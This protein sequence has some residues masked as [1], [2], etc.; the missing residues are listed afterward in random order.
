MHNN[1]VYIVHVFKSYTFDVHELIVIARDEAI[2][3][4]HKHQYFD[5]IIFLH[6][7]D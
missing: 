1:D 7:I 3:G 2:Q 6:L 5:H 4:Q